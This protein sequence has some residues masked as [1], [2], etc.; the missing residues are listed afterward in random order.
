[1]DYAA[2]DQ[3]VSNLV[4]SKRIAIV[5]PSDPQFGIVA[6]CDVNVYVNWHE[7]YAQFLQ[8]QCP[9]IFYIS[10]DQ[11]RGLYKSWRSRIAD[12][13][14]LFWNMKSGDFLR[15][16]KPDPFQFPHFKVQ[17]YTNPRWSFVYDL[18][19]SVRS[20]PLTGFIAL[21]H[22][23]SFNPEK[24]FITGWDLYIG[25]DVNNRRMGRPHRDTHDIKKHRKLLAEMIAADKRIM[26]EARLAERIAE[27]YPTLAS[28]PAGSDIPRNSG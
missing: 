1:M 25:R 19:V 15:G 20:S 27:Y 11:G 6:D 8:L 2:A 9:K 16:E 28:A 23:L 14:L 24:V 13:C 18:F 21:K 10:G 4:R 12:P 22:L 3:M 17:R 5:G 7:E 26:I